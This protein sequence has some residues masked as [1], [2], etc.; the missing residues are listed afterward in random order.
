MGWEEESS[1]ILSKILEKWVLC[2]YGKPYYLER[3]DRLLLNAKNE[4]L[5]NKIC[6]LTVII[7][8]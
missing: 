3:K 4:F 5:K 8:P 6:H 7:I 1:H 2:W